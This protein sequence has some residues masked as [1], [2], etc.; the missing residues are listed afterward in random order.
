MIAAKRDDSFELQSGGRDDEEGKYED[1]GNI[2]EDNSI[3]FAVGKKIGEKEGRSGMISIFLQVW[4]SHSLR[5]KLL[6]GD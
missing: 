2:W 4:W 1:L 5:K 6:E 3:R